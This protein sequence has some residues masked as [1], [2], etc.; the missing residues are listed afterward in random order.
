MAGMRVPHTLILLLAMNA[1]ALVLAYV[2]PQGAFER[3]EKDGREQVVA[4]TYAPLEEAERVHPLSLFTAIPRGFA[5]AQEII[6]FVFLIGGAFAVLRATGAIDAMIGRLLEHLGSRPLWFVAGGMLVF[7]IGSS[8]IGMA[9]EYIPFVPVLLALAIGLGFDAITAI[10]ILCVGYGIGYGAAIFNPFTV[11]IAQD[12]AEVQPASGM[13]FRIALWLVLIVVGVHHVYRYA[14]RVRADPAASL[15][16]DVEPDP[17]WR[18]TETRALAGRDLLVLGLT[19]AAIALIVYGLK[20]LHWYV[21]E[22]G[23][24]FLGLSIVLVVL[25]RMSADHAAREFCTGAAELTTTALLIGFARSILILLEDGQVIDTVV[26]Y[27]SQ[28]LDAAGSIVAAVGMLFFQSL[29]NLFIPSGSGQAYVTMPVM[30]PIGDL[31]GVNR[32]VAVL[33]YQIGDGLTNILVPTNAV[34][35]GILAMARIPYERWVRFVFPFILK[36][37]LVCA[38]ALAVAVLTGW[39]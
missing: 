31:V 27:V 13:G 32:Q 22:M 11:L 30:A 15:V 20:E 16:A 9:E 8:T 39:S 17:S 36:A 14:T 18:V 5:A 38:V 21:I 3:V 4:G 2:L 29:C 34:L 12:I 37:L 23:A 26:H 35:V 6:F 19:L 1:A 10:G 33:A 25:T 24:V 7:S 28:P